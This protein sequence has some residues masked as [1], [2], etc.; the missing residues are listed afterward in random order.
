MIGIRSMKANHKSRWLQ[1]AIVLVSCLAV[2]SALPA[3]IDANPS[4]YRSRLSA[5]QPGDIL[6]LTAG[7]YS[8]NL[9][10]TA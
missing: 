3:V 5:L 6:N 2:S 7:D 4:N 1:L 8:N 10:K 9:P